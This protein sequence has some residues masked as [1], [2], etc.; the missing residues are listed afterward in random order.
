MLEKIT[1]E[2]RDFIEGLEDP[3]CATEIIFSDLDNFL[4]EEEN[5]F[6]EV[7]MSQIPML[8]FE[9]MIDDEN[10]HLGRDAKENKK[11]NF[12]Q[13]V[14][15]GSIEC[16]GGRKFGKTHF[17]EK[18]DMFLSFIH[19]PGEHVGFT[20]LDLLHIKGIL[21]DVIKVLEN[22]TFFKMFQ[23]KIQ[24]APD[25]RITLRNGYVLDAINM[26]LQAPNPG[27]GFF[28][29]HLK[30]LYIEEGSFET[31]TVYKK[32]IDAVSEF[33]AV[34]RAAGMTN[35]TRYMP[36]GR[37]F[38]DLE[39]RD[40]V[41]NLPQYCNPM[42]DDKQ[43][44]KA[45]KEHGGENSISYRIFVKGEV[46]EEGISVFD[47]ERVRRHYLEDK[48]V[49]HFELTKDNFYNFRNVLILDRPSSIEEVYIC[50]DIGESAP[51]EIIILFKVGETFKY[52]YNITCYNLTDKQQP[53]IFHYLAQ[54][55]NANIIALDTTDGTGRSIYRTLNE[56]YPAQNLVF[57]SFNE[58][59]NVDFQKDDND[60]ILFGNDGKPL[61]KQEYV[62]E[63][64][65]LRLKELLYA[66]KVLLP[67]DYKLDKQ[68]NSVVCSNT[69]A[70]IAYKVVGDEDHLFSAFRVFAIAEWSKNFA[71][72]TALG[73]K[74]FF[75]G[76]V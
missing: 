13:R 24:R 38:F 66:G 23:A 26:K 41:C 67:I 39:N 32:R 18:V 16:F 9:Y 40:I 35:F 43:K 34:I 21:E 72:N 37:R 64:S 10:P 45:I 31:E 12:Q 68:I 50:A 42:W 22:H 11:L 65:V 47:M 5:M 48:F 49:K 20:S 25:Y 76:G 59:I 52:V 53:D 44:Q 69:G 75:K 33:G 74:K 17:V 4:L 57:C 56:T 63:Y 62:S 36:A 54:T 70:R 55:L 60:N 6:A 14:K 58:K 8:S 51:T 3:L 15:A 29:K 1:D 30:R 19:L 73:F 46:V 28:Q 71:S 61:Y 7:R 2:E 27:D